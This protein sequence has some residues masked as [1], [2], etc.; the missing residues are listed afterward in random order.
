MP[1]DIHHTAKTNS[2]W[3]LRYIRARYID[4][5]HGR[6]AD[7][8]L[9]FCR[10]SRLPHTYI[11]HLIHS[12]HCTVLGLRDTVNNLG[13]KIVQTVLHQIV[14]SICTYIWWQYGNLPHSSKA[15]R[16]TERERRERERATEMQCL[17]S[18]Q[19][20]PVYGII[21][22]YETRYWLNCLRHWNNES[23]KLK[24]PRSHFTFYFQKTAT[25]WTVP[26]PG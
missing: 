4:T 15:V 23:A 25:H 6:R 16:H 10:F 7:T 14:A 22:F 18:W 9:I 20:K 21:T 3:S 24:Q 2:A 12:K 26:R 13:P 1:Q 19:T 17:F 8:C 11:G 5:I